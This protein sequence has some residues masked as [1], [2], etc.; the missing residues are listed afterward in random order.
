MYVSKALQ[1][2]KIEVNEDGT[3]ASAATSEYSCSDTLPPQSLLLIIS[4]DMFF[5]KIASSAAILLARS[6]PPWVSVERPFLFL[7]RHNPTGKT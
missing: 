1:K 2:A 3:K 5:Y 6:S 7:I 4:P